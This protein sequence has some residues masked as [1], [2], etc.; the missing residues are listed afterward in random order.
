VAF[1]RRPALLDR[2][3][4][5]DLAALGGRLIEV[6]LKRLA[7]R[8]EVA[9]AIAEMD[10]QRVRVRG[11]AVTLELLKVFELRVRAEAALDCLD[12]PMREVGLRSLEEQPIPGLEFAGYLE[13][14]RRF[15][16]LLH[17]A[18]DTVRCLLIYNPLHPSR[19]PTAFMPMGIPMILT[20][21]HKRDQGEQ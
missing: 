18:V 14:L 19:L 13:K 21:F 9:T 20:A 1:L 10:F 4:R 15:L 2:L 5:R 3:R 17:R 6:P 12:C 8:E 16:L 7:A 11:L